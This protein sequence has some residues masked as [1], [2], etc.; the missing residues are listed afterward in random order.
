MRPIA[1]P[2]VEASTG[3]PREGP[4]LQTLGNHHECGQLDAVVRLSH[5][6]ATSSLVFKKLQKNDKYARENPLTVP[7]LQLPVVWHSRRSVIQASLI[8][9]GVGCSMFP[10]SC[11]SGTDWGSL[12]K[13]RWETS[14]VLLLESGAAP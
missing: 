6:S 1:S 11:A 5:I 10:I 14:V 3:R 7:E 9:K 4:Q 2:S 8:C 13:S 12:R